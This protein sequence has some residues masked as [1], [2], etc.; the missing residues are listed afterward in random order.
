MEI[1]DYWL[2]ILIIDH[3]SCLEVTYNHWSYLEVST[4]QHQKYWCKL[5]CMDPNVKESEK[6][7]QELQDKLKVLE[8]LKTHK[9]ERFGTRKSEKDNE[10]TIAITDQVEW[11]LPAAHIYHWIDAGRQEAEKD[12]WRTTEV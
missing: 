4:I 7:K 5:L 6:Q 11:M 2:I 9:F 1:N 10:I 8:N 3:W 12:E